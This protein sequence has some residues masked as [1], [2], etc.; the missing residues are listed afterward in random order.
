MAG[1]TRAEIAPLTGTA[2]A[3]LSNDV[4]LTSGL[5]SGP[6]FMRQRPEFSSIPIIVLSADRNVGPKAQDIGAVGHLAKPFE[7]NDLLEM[8]RRALKGPPSTS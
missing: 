7:L 3:Q 8:V 1:G 4:T 6:G 2:V 5:R